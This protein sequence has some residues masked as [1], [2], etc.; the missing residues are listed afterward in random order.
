MPNAAVVAFVFRWNI[1]GNIDVERVPVG[2]SSKAPF[3]EGDVEG[4][5]V[6][7]A[8]RNSAI[9]SAPEAAHRDGFVHKINRFCPPDR[10]GEFQLENARISATGDE[11]ILVEEDDERAFREHRGMF[12]DGARKGNRTPTLAVANS[13]RPPCLRF[14]GDQGGKMAQTPVV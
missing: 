12:A 11:G 5:P 9:F 2:A 14:A 3:G 1:E 6:D 4:H 10:L 7:V 8:G 13:A